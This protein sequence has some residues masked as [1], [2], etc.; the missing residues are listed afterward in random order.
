MESIGGFRYSSFPFV[1][2]NILLVEGN[3]ENSRFSNGRC[4]SLRDFHR[5]QLTGLATQAKARDE[6][7]RRRCPTSS[8]MQPLFLGLC[9]CLT[10]DKSES[11]AGIFDVMR[12]PQVSEIIRLGPSDFDNSRLWWLSCLQIIG[13][14]FVGAYM[15]WQCGISPKMENRHIW[16][17][18]RSVIASANF[19]RFGLAPGDPGPIFTV[20]TV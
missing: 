6:P 5:R 12:L 1:F 17:W 3:T 9:W 13:N 16:L 10:V 2:R 8:D 11:D 18:L 15:M 4:C 14:S 20:S 19:V 7:H